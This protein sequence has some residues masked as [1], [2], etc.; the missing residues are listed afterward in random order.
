MA[1][2]PLSLSVHK[3]PRLAVLAAIPETSSSFLSVSCA[4]CFGA[5]KTF[6]SPG[7]DLSGKQEAIET[8]INMT[9]AIR[10]GDVKIAAKIKQFNVYR[11]TIVCVFGRQSEL[12]NSACGKTQEIR[13]LRPSVN[14]HSAP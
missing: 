2:F 13:G 6:E 12:L 7:A 11:P 3:N 5:R 8:Q 10:I 9:E 4:S 14:K 1:G